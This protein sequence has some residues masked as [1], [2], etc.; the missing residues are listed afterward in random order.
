[1]GK[2]IH[3]GQSFELARESAR[4][5]AHIGQGRK[6]MVILKTLDPDAEEQNWILV[7]KEDLP[8][9]LKEADVM[10]NLVL[11][12]LAKPPGS[13]WW[14]R[15]EALVAYEETLQATYAAKEYMD[16]DGSR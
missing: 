13:E 7:K 2:I 11:G 5:A 4:R 6:N 16:N 15:A 8:D 3:A 1:M 10:G 12:M 9:H 14:Y